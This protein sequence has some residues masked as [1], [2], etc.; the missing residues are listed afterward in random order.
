M[1]T[2]QIQWLGAKIK[3]RAEGFETSDAPNRNGSRKDRVMA[4]K[5]LPSPEVLRQLL[6]YDPAT[7]A[8]HWNERS[9]DW[10]TD[11]KRW[12]REANCDRWN[13][14]YKGTPALS[15]IDKKGYFFGK[16]FSD[17]HR[18]HRIIWAMHYGECGGDFIDHIDGNRGNNR[19]EN[20]RLVSRSVNARNA[21]CFSTN[22]S[23]FSGVKVKKTKTGV[24]YIARANI[25][26]RD[27]YL[28]QFNEIEDA[29][30]ARRSFND[31][32]GFGPNHGRKHA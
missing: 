30:A 18:A 7:G 17:L 16:V 3:R 23:G 10:F 9:V 5:A 29:V 31:Q 2:L 12:K 25:M 26:G 13:T 28:G 32:H 22:T 20:L 27:I 14:R 11:G 6:S 4:E 15:S 21:K 24:T 19:L 1:N 8:L